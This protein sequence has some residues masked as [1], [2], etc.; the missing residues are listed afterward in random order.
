MQP[1]I[2]ERAERRTAAW[3]RKAFNGGKTEKNPFDCRGVSEVL[4]YLDHKA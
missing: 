2:Y 3:Q 4:S 1:W